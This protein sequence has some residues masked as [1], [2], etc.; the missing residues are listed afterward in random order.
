MR[1]SEEMATPQPAFTVKI[2]TAVDAATA[3]RATQ[4]DIASMETNVY[5]MMAHCNR[6]AERRGDDDPWVVSYRVCIGD[7]LQAIEEARATLPELRRAIALEVAR[8]ALRDS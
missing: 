4:H 6:A 8:E 3:L 2:P 5:S 1:S 7:L